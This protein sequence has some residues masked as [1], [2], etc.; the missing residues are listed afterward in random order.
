MINEEGSLISL[1]R[2]LAYLTKTTKRIPQ[3]SIIGNI[4]GLSTYKL[5]WINK[6]DL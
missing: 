2:V 5:K 4:D 6:H 1:A 3:K